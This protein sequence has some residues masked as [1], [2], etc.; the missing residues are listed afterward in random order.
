MADQDS[1]VRKQIDEYLEKLNT[2]ANNAANTIFDARDVAKRDLEAAKNEARTSI[3][4]L[5]KAIKRYERQKVDIA[6]LSDK[7]AVLQSR[8]DIFESSLGVA[9]DQAERL[10]GIVGKVV[11]IKSNRSV[12]M[13]AAAVDGDARIVCVRMDGDGYV[14]ISIPFAALEVVQQE[15]GAK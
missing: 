6:S 2:L 12:L 13:T 4:M 7:A 10:V 5:E 11:C 9:E 1:I 8:L 14:E 15:G 3:D